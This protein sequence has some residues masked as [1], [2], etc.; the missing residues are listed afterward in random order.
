MLSQQNMENHLLLVRIVMKNF[1]ISHRGIY[2]CRLGTLTFFESPSHALHFII[3]SNY[4]VISVLL[5][6]PIVTLC[7]KKEGS[8]SPL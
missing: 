2:F 5:S 4:T 3:S 6:T 8:I 7:N 1:Y